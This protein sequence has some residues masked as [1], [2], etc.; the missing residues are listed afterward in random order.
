MYSRRS[1]M[2]AKERKIRLENIGNPPFGRHFFRLNDAFLVPS[3]VVKI[4]TQK[5][6]SN[7]FLDPLTKEKVWGK[8]LLSRGGKGRGIVCRASTLDVNANW[9]ETQTAAQWVRMLCRFRAPKRFQRWW[10]S[11]RIEQN[12]VFH[13]SDWY[14]CDPIGRFNGVCSYGKVWRVSRILF[15][16][17]STKADL[18]L[19]RQLVACFRSSYSPI[20]F[21]KHISSS[22]FVQ[23]KF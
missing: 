11:S 22:V 13:F 14:W 20:L 18:N 4:S 19:S 6:D 23:Y 21:T 16:Y 10:I 1:S 8:I 15:S 5:T 7:W 12:I 17:S 3:K 2:I 9:S